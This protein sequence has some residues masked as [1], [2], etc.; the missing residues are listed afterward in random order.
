MT[1]QENMLVFVST[2]TTE[3]KPVKLEMETSYTEML[4]HM[5]IFLADLQFNLIGFDE[6]RKYVGICKYRNYRIQTSQTGDGDQLY[7]NAPSYGNFFS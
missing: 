7:R 5:V 6:T 1:K 4:P 3:S 2:E